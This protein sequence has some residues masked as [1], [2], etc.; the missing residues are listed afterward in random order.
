MKRSIYI[1]D[2]Q[3]AVLDTA[4]LILRGLD[5][6]WEVTGFSEPLAALAA[7]QAKAPDLILSDQ[8]MPGMLGSQLLEEVRKAAP[9][10]IRVIMSGYVSLNKLTLIT[11]A[12]QYIAKPFDIAKLRDLVRRSFAAQERIVNQGLQSMATSLRSIPSLPQVHQSLLAELQDDRTAGS[13]IARM[14]A[15]D[16]GL[17]IKVL[18]L[19]NS[20]LFGQGYLIT[21]PTDAVMRLGTEMIAAIVLSQSLFRH[22]EKL[23]H[24][25]LESGR[26]WS[27]CWE[28]AYLAQH[29]CR[30]KRLPRR[31]SEEAFLAGLLHEA[32]RYI[33]VDNFPEQFTVACQSARQANSPLAPRLQETFQATPAQL[34]A[35]LMELWGMPT[36]VVNAIGLLDHPQREPGGAFTLASALYVADH[37]AARKVPPDDFALEEWNMAYLQAIGCQNDLAQWDDPSFP[38]ETSREQ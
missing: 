35:Y 28:T 24:E 19:A 27:H 21:N 5:A 18:Q 16:A 1:V 15:D 2:D 17:S 11:S 10:A 32:G 38:H 30:L 9:T 13:A 22:Y 4:I 33:L 14:V 7:V 6:Q 29:L 12:H 23:A 31:A 8:L 20:P 36:D 25:E 3:A 26:I 34:T 37:I